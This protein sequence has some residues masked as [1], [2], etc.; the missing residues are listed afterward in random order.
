MSSSASYPQR[1]QPCISAYHILRGHNH[2]FQHIMPAVNEPSIPA[3]HMHGVEIRH[4]KNIPKLPHII[5]TG[6]AAMSSST[7]CQQERVHH[8]ASYPLRCSQESQLI[9]CTADTT[10]SYGILYPQVTQPYS[11]VHHTNMPTCQ[12]SPP[13]FLPPPSPPPLRPPE[14]HGQPAFGAHDLRN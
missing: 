5:S 3:H 1:T 14:R 6:D 13:I 10:N 11:T 2:E 4:A 8:R 7:S 9:I 12:Q